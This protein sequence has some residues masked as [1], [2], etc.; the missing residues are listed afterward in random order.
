MLVLR[1]HNLARLR[2]GSIKCADGL[3]IGVG[4][5]NA[6]VRSAAGKL[7]EYVDVDPAA[8]FG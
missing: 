4:A 3:S 7:D 1:A 6:P 2:P 5:T 8:L